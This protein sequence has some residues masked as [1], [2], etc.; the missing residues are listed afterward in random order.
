MTNINLSYSKGGSLRR[1][2]EPFS[3]GGLLRGTVLTITLTSLLTYGGVVG[4]LHSTPTRRPRREERPSTGANSDVSSRRPLASTYRPAESRVSF[5]HAVLVSARGPQRFLGR[6]PDV[7]RGE[8]HPRRPRTFCHH[9]THLVPSSLGYPFSRYHS[10]PW[11]GPGSPWVVTT[12][13]GFSHRRDGLG[14]DRPSRDPSGMGWRQGVELRVG[15]LVNPFSPGP[16][17]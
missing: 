10:R 15:P 5:P 7:V 16:S 8:P 2:S 11:C 6:S 1:T 13:G 14:P 9:P 4:A 17:L 3:G 12:S